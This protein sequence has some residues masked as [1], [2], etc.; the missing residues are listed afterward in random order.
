MCRVCK[1][2]ACWPHQFVFSTKQQKTCKAQKKNTLTK[3]VRGHVSSSWKW[4]LHVCVIGCKSCWIVRI[5]HKGLMKFCIW[6]HSLQKANILHL[7][8][9]FRHQTQLASITLIIRENPLNGSTRPPTQ[10]ECTGQ[11]AE[12]HF[13]DRNIFIFFPP[14][15]AKH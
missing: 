5:N 1:P 4:G 6:K 7:Q 2:A 15:N 8:H 12:S 14:P 9:I 3:N 11:N 10:Q 13:K